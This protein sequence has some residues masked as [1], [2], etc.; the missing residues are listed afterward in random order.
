MADPSDDLCIEERIDQAKRL[1]SVYSGFIRSSIR[2]FVREESERDDIYQ[3]LFIFFVR[4]PLPKDVNNIKGFLYRVIADRIRDLRRKKS[5]YQNCLVRYAETVSEVTEEET[6]TDLFQQ[7]QAE[8]I[9]R[10][11]QIYLTENEARAITLRYKHE[12]DIHKTAETM[13]VQPKTISRYVCIG[14]KKIREVFKK[15]ERAQHEE[16]E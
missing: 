12:Y 7:E 9:Y 16:G 3:E 1:F 13:G 2:Y 6:L 4:K 5:R 8:E 14:L 15:R 10:I 11:L